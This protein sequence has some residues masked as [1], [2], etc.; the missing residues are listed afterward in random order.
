MRTL[1]EPASAVEAHML[2]DLLGQAGIA[3]EIHG[4]SLSGAM[5]GLPA[6]GLVRLSV[7]EADYDRARGLIEQWEAQ[8]PRD[9]VPEPMVKPGSGPWFWL[10]LGFL[11]GLAVAQI[12]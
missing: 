3:V 5:G 6:A 7:D 12:L 11:L 9:A 4:E 8:Q 10:A 2:Q 1:Y